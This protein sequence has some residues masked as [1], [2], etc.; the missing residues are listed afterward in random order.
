MGSR[1]KSPVRHPG[2]SVSAGHSAAVGSKQLGWGLEHP[3]ARGWAPTWATAGS[4]LILPAKV[5]QLPGVLNQRVAGW[6]RFDP[7][8]RSKHPEEEF[9]DSFEGS[10]GRAERGEDHA[11]KHGGEHELEELIGVDGR[12][13]RIG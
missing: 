4:N 6:T 5:A 12:V 8:S 10:P 3:T 9:D 1:Y 13:D 7:A 11:P 2:S